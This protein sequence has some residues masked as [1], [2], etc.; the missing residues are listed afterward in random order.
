[1][2]LIFHV[3][4]NKQDRGLKV[5]LAPSV[6]LASC[7]PD[8]CTCPSAWSLPGG[9]KSSY[10]IDDDPG[11]I[12][13][14]WPQSVRELSVEVQELHATVPPSTLHDGIWGHLWRIDLQA[15]RAGGEL[16]S[17]GIASASS[18]LSPQRSSF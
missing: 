3:F 16:V 17:R 14:G 7:L 9:P 1:M 8:Q 15:L 12:F 4:L 11:H 10:P 6:A 5:P 18:L 2:F 13:V